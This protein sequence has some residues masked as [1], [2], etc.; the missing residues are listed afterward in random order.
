MSQ[1]G[2]QIVCWIPGVV[3]EVNWFMD[4]VP[5]GGRGQGQL[6]ARV[7]RLGQRQGQLQQKYCQRCY[8]LCYCIVVNSFVKKIKDKTMSIF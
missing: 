3:L 4:N 7:L 6:L 5:E 8:V 2:G 1:V